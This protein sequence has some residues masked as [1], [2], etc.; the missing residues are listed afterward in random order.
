MAKKK[1]E[2]VQT[3]DV[4]SSAPTPVVAPPVAPSEPD[5]VIAEVDFNE[6]LELEKA[7]KQTGDQFNAIAGN[8][9]RLEKDL[10]LYHAH[11]KALNEQ[12][13]SKRKELIRRYGINKDRQW[14]IDFNSRKVVYVG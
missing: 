9:K 7:T 5:V 12:I 13:D 8:I 3:P 11:E 1:D 14:R 4:V 10:D 2:V 6:L